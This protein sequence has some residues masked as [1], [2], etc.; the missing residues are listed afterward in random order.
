M[1][2]TGMRTFADGLGLVAETPPEAVLHHGVSG[3]TA[4]VPP[5]R[6]PAV[7]E[8]AHWAFG[9]SMAAVF[10]LLP[11]RL[12]RHIWSGP[13][14]GAAVWTAFEGVLTPLLGLPR[15]RHA[16]YTER[17]VLLADHLA[18]GAIIG[19]RGANR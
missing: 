14:F 7:V 13:L 18:Y 15:M 9:A 11:A 1:A 3:F 6:R 5:E 12:R 19:Q 2:M 16:R 8:L 17:L 4:K 10:A